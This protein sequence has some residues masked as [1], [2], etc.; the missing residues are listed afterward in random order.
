MREKFLTRIS[1]LSAEGKCFAFD[2][3]ASG[4]GRGDGVA[5]ILIKPLETALRDGDPIRA[6]IR[7]TAANQDGKT[8]TLTSPS[9]EAQQTLMRECYE[10]A[11]LNPVDTAYVEAHGTGTQAGDTIEAHALGTVFG[12]GRPGEHPLLIGSVKTNIGHTEAASGLAGIIKA[13]M[14]LEKGKIPPHLNY[15]SPNEK[16]SLETLKLK[17]GQS[18]PF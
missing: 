12:N 7:N 14:A 17:V 15:E 13:V 16:I 2:S 1:L 5:T 6:V 10:V 18:N 11:A 9:Q 4:Y 3:R 8:A